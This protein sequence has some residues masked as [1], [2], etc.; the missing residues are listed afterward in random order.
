MLKG[1]SVS[2][3]HRNPLVDCWGVN[4]ICFLLV[5]IVATMLNQGCKCTKKEGSGISPPERPGHSEGDISFFLAGQEHG[6]SQTCALDECLDQGGQDHFAAYVVVWTTASA[7]TRIPRH[8]V[9]PRTKK[10]ISVIAFSLL[11]VFGR[12][13][14]D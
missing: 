4:M 13:C 6:H 11:S 8:T 14:W 9:K 5:S 12:M 3:N 10:P 2:K 1:H 7:T